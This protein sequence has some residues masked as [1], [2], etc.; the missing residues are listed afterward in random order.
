MRTA[1]TRLVLAATLVFLLVTS[2]SVGLAVA[3][4][5]AAQYE[6]TIINLTSGQPLTPPVVVTH[7]KATGI[8]DVGSSASFGI[9]QI[10]EN[11][12][13]GPL[14]AALASDKHVFDV[15]T[16]MAPLVPAGTPGSGMFGD[17][18]TLHITS[19]K[20]ANYLSFA[21]MLI[22]TNDGFTGLDTLRLPKKVG[23]VI[24]AFTMG[25]D[26]GTEVNTEDFADI[27]PPCQGLI[28]ITSPDAG[29]GMTNPA[30]AEGGVIVVHPGIVGGMDLVPGAHGWMD[31]VVQVII[32]RVS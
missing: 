22:C 25:Y 23:E 24:V 15:T 3:K 14:L 18:V 7:K 28:G 27:V 20:G 4:P 9:Q 32:T 19:A 17:T 29:T 6:V 1:L 2:A 10:A 31:P 11:G 30:L 8:F 21:T 12:D 13:N 26:A 5:P 16:G